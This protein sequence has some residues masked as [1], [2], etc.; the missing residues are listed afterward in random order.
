MLYKSAVAG[1]RMPVLHYLFL[2]SFTNLRILQSLNHAVS[3]PGLRPLRKHLTQR[4]IQVCV[5]IVVHGDI[6]ASRPRFLVQR[7]H[8]R[9]LV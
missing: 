3:A 2:N 6:N 5:G 8:C 1:S 4:R 9:Q 7:E